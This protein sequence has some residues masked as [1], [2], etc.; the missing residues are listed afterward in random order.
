MTPELAI[1]L[2]GLVT[3]LSAWLRIANSRRNAAL[4]LKR[5]RQAQRA[6]NESDAIRRAASLSQPR[7][8]QQ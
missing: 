6:R 8:R 4:R 7:P 2:T 1:A 3:A 5:S